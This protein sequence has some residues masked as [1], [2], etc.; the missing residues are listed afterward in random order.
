M[1]SI[2][3]SLSSC[4]VN[5]KK[6]TSSI[7][8]IKI[9]MTL[10]KQEDVFVSSIT[11]NI[12]EIA[13]EK[14]SDGKYKITMNILDAKG[15]LN[16]QNNQVDKFIAQDYDIICVNLVDRTAAAVII[17]KAKAAN[18]PVI[19]FNRE[20][21]EEDME[22]WNRL[23]YVGAE[24]E[25][26][27]EMQADII[28]NAYKR[29]KQKVDKNGDGKIQYVM[30]EGEQGHQDTSIRTEYCIKTITQNGIEV[31]KLA[32]D[33]ANWEGAQATTKMTKWIKTFGDKI[34]VVFCNN[35]AM[36]L[37]AVR[38][39]DNLNITENR[40]LI[41]GIDGLPDALSAVKNGLMAGTVINDSKAQANSIFNIAYDLAINGNVNSIKGLVNG[42]YIRTS[43]AR[44]TNDN[45]DV[46]LENK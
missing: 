3:T 43:H 30:L 8:E 46:F 1:G 21:V 36:A 45:I 15:N 5:T 40:P 4:T 2:C 18:K 28:I 38:A 27:G 25:Q 35:D 7:K 6:Y 32:D 22:R 29:D 42:K 11:K 12:E 19:F 23:Y 37:G 44:V 33:T 31:E 10:Y 24:A 34:E 41:V 39:L 9:G 14:E 20:P 13:K 26:S 16:N 17:D